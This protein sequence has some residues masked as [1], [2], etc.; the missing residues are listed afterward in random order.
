MSKQKFKRG[1]LVRVAKNLGDM[2]SHFRNDADAII[3]GS[4]ADQFGG[5]AQQS[6]SYTLVFIEDG[7]QSS[8]YD[9]NQLTLL[10]EGGEHL[11]DEANKKRE[12]IEKRNITLEYIS[13]NIEGEISSQSILFLFEMLGHDCAFNRNGEFYCIFSDWL[14]LQPVFLHIFKSESTNEAKTIFTEQGL[15]MY[16][17]EPVYK[18]FNPKPNERNLSKDS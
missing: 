15:K 10:D 3:F 6:K 13:E 12:E 4:Y 14:Q 16:D 1:N 5:G 18:F 2:M 9:E 11:F 8:W 7:G 17:I